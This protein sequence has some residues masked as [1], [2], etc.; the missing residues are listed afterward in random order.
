MSDTVAGTLSAVSRSL[1]RRD[2]LLAFLLLGLGYPLVYLAVI[3]HLSLNGD[4]GV[5]AFVVSDPLSRALTARS[6]F[7]WEPI[8]RV[9]AGPL[10]YLFSPLNLALAG[11]LGALVG[12]NG[13]VA[14][15]SY[16]APV[17]CG[18]EQSAGLLAA[19]PALLSGAA[20]CGPAFLLLVGVQ[21]SATL[22][23]VVGAAVP[24][25]VALLV[26]SLL[27]VGRSASPPPG[28]REVAG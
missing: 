5:S 9:V 3:G 17:A 11:V 28:D 19:V 6:P 21:A 20:C 13:A 22:L 7:S 2:G 26:V 10:H 18:V 23:G 14:L 16:R 12:L 4:G 15:V 8:A 27:L 25:S 24:A 1:D